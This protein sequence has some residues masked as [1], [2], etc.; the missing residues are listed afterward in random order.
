[1]TPIA[2]HREG[3]LARTRKSFT[4]D[5]Y[6]SFRIRQLIAKLDP[7]LADRSKGGHC[8]AWS[9]TK[10]PSVLHLDDDWLALEPI[11]P[12]RVEPLFEQGVGAVPFL[13]M[14]KHI[15]GLRR[16][17]SRRVVRKGRRIVEDFRVLAFSTWPGV[18]KDDFLRPAARLRKPEPDPEKQFF[19][20]L[21]RPSIP[22]HQ[23]GWRADQEA[24]FARSEKAWRLPQ[25]VA[26][27]GDAPSPLARSCAQDER[28]A[29]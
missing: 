24:W 7:F 17:T 11:T 10:A 15:R 27:D 14:N 12:G 3:L 18:I 26:S 20:Q 28:S 8:R 4:R 16:R 9:A 13:S 23:P 6:P 25:N 1:M 19:R 5:V 2:E 29:Q 22:R 21:N